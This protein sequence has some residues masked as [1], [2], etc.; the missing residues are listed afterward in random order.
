MKWNFLYLKQNFQLAFKL[1]STCKIEEKNYYNIYDAVKLVK[2]VFWLSSERNLTQV[3]G[4]GYI[5][6]TR[7][8]T[9]SPALNGARVNEL[10]DET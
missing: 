6:K 7:Q 4:V 1:W 3:L 2:M 5:W 8:S 10:T 9:G